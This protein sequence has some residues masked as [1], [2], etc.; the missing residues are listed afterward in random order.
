MYGHQQ[1]GREGAAKALSQFRGRAQHP[2]A[3]KSTTLIHND[4]QNEVHPPNG[5]DLTLMEVPIN[6]KQ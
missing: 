6:S 2:T 1:S 4:V 3:E 5:Y